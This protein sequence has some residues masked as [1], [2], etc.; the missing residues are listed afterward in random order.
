MRYLRATGGLAGT[1]AYLVIDDDT[2]KAVLFD[3]PD[4]TVA[5]LLDAVEREGLELIGLWLTHGHFDHLAD[6]QHVTDRFPNAEVL[7][8]RFDADRLRKPGSSMFPL[9]FVIPPREPTRT[10]EDGQTL[11]LG[12]LTA[13]VLHTPGHA[14]GHVMFHF[15]ANKLLIGGDLII[16]GAVGRT[17]LPGS[18]ERQ[19]IDSVR[20]V[21]ALP[22][23]TELLPGHGE[24]GTLGQE[25]ATNRYVQA[26]LRH[27]GFA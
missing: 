23:D 1:N 13:T 17:D 14:P 2:S 10:I 9:P 24:P 7:I 8:H 6:H 22:D 21:M 25:R 11:Q 12:N 15:E 18:D 16:G 26:I 5:P 4:H 27:G 19:M 20:R 3:A